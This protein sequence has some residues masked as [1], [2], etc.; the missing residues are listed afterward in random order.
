MNKLTILF[1][2]DDPYLG[3][4]IKDL[5][6]LNAYNVLFAKTAESGMELF[7][8]S[9]P[10]ICVLDVMLP[11]MDG[12]ELGKKIRSINKK[13]PI[14][15]LTAR[16]MK[17]DVIEGFKIGAD[18]YIKKPFNMEELILRIQAI[19]RRAYDISESTNEKEIFEFG[20]Y[21]FMYKK[22]Q[23]HY[24]GKEHKLTHKESEI[25]K[26]LCSNPDS[27][28]NREYILT[29]TW[30]ENSYFNARSMDVFIAKLRTHFKNDPQIEI[31]NI[32]GQGFKLI[33]S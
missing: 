9:D 24:D 12:F 2:E 10:D 1:V 19:I 32:R 21:T 11:K 27:V 23:L 4:V 26:M 31:V 13:L 8:K 3:L 7:L 15:Y 5:F 6:E 17:E 28:I 22:K 16:S 25:L 29:K 20:K 30:G 14:I 18:D 33:I